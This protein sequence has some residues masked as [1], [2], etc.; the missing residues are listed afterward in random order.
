MRSLVRSLER[1]EMSFHSHRETQRNFL[2]TM[3]VIG[4]RQ[5]TYFVKTFIHGVESN[6]LVN[7]LVVYTSMLIAMTA[8]LFV[9]SQN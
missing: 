7:H 3:Q 5:M 8:N 6:A 2:T 4:I 9:A 1:I